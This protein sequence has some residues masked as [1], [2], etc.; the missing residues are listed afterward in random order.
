[1]NK[2]N[3]HNPLRSSLLL[4]LTAVIWGF[5]FVSQ[6]VGAQYVGPYT[7]LA[8]R[9]WLAVLFLTVV[10]FIKDR[11]KKDEV[12]KTAEQK[13]VLL[14]AGVIVGFFLFT[15][16]L[17]QQIGVADTTTA[18]AGFI[19]AL[20]V[21]LVPVFSVFRGH[22]VTKQIWFCVLLSIVGLYFLCFNGVVGFSKGDIFMLA[23]AVMFSFQILAIN[24]FIA[25][26]DGVRLSRIEMMV[27]AVLSTILMLIFEGIDLKAMGLALIPILYAGI[28]SSGVGYTLQIVAQDG[29]NPTVASLIMCLESVFSAVGGWMILHQ[30]LSIRELC[31]C[32]LMF[33]AIVLAQLPNKK[34]SV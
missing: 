34:E 4:L 13:R 9:S 12:P 31:G 30:S 25:Y 17:L 6:S 14:K 8:S 7:F 22:S 19:T 3:H 21:V 2:T 32:A 28:M 29:L 24:H 20:Y 5:A 23:C 18:K 15:A 1:M 16:S 26:V 11:I 10:I 33:G 27:T